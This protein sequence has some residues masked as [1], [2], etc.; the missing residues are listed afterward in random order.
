MTSIGRD[1]KVEFR[2]YRPDVCKVRIA[3]D[4]TD[5]RADLPMQA[6]GAGWW[7][8]KTQL[9]PGEY[10]FR[11]LADGHWFTDFA[12]N[13]VESSELGMNSILI[14]KG[15]GLSADAQVSEQPAPPAIIGAVKELNQQAKSA[16]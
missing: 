5:W 16:A 8:L 14:V 12:A 1:G 13:G 11:Y 10:R 9:P 15:N 7:T 2:F 6:E 4:F 3:G